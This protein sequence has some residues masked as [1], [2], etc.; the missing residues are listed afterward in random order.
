MRLIR[1]RSFL[2]GLAAGIFAPA[3][4]RAES[5]M[6]VRS[7][8]MPPALVVPRAA[9]MGVPRCDVCFGA[10]GMCAHSGGPMNLGLPSGMDC[11]VVE[12]L[13]IDKVNYSLMRKLNS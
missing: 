6:P 4:V 1:R 7:I 2:I 13:D 3:I 11:R 8:I 10:W 9:V 12:N 5:L